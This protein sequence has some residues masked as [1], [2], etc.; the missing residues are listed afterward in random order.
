M[1]GRRRC[2]AFT[3]VTRAFNQFVVEIGPGFQQ[4]DRPVGRSIVD[5]KHLQAEISTLTAPTFEQLDDRGF[6]V[7]RGIRIVTLVNFFFSVWR[8]VAP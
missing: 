6:F 2:G 1:L 3:A 5:D 8:K 7:V 4:F